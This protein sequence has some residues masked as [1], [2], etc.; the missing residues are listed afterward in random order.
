MTSQHFLIFTGETASLICKARGVPNVTFHWARGS[1]GQ[2]LSLGSKY[3][4]KNVQV[5]P[6]NFRSE[7]LIHNVSS[8]D[9]GGYECIARN[10]EGTTHSTIDLDVK[11][12]PGMIS[13]ARDLLISL[14]PNHTW[15]KNTVVVKLS[16]SPIMVFDLKWPKR[17]RNS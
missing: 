3:Q 9:Y 1:G 17:A 12:R 13:T 14:L 4:V 11:S 15:Y 7:L 6:L 16:K 2:R 5:D 8:V 10:S